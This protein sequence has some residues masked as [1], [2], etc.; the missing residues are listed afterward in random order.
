MSRF[1][2]IRWLLLIVISLAFVTIQGG[3]NGAQ[4]ASA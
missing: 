2:L 1:G 4:V 3:V